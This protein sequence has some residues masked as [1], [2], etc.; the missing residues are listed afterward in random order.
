MN[1]ATEAKATVQSTWER[2]ARY[3]ELLGEP[4]VPL[5]DLLWHS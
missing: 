5:L 4:V 2:R 1:N 3:C